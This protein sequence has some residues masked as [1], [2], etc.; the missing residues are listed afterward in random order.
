MEALFLSRTPKEDHFAEHCYLACSLSFSPLLIALLFHQVEFKMKKTD[1]IRWEKL[2]G[3]GQESNIKHFDPSQSTASAFTLFP[4]PSSC[5][6]SH[7]SVSPFL[8]HALLI[9]LFL[10]LSLSLQRSI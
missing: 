3:E 9:P 4:Q 2:E 1:A 5:L 6:C 10:S 7:L 8:P